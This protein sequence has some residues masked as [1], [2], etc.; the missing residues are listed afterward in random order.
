ML[1]HLLRKATGVF[2]NSVLLIGCGKQNY[3]HCDVKVVALARISIS[4]STKL[5]MFEKKNIYKEVCYR[6][7][8]KNSSQISVFSWSR[9]T[10]S[11]TI[12]SSSSSLSHRIAQNKKKIIILRSIVLLVATS[13]LFWILK[14][15]FLTISGTWSHLEIHMKP[16]PIM[17]GL[18]VILIIFITRFSCRKVLALLYQYLGI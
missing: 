7:L 3:V 8:L 9:D 13:L 12:P 10:L 5:I 1:F 17:S 15:Y 16:Y 11:L 18:V 6:S 4:S 14:D 2:K